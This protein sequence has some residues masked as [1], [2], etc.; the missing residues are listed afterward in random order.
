MFRKYLITGLLIWLPLGITLLILETI[1]GWMDQSLLLLPPP[2]RPEALL[3]FRIPGLG[4]LLAV[5]VLLLTGVLARNIVGRRLLLW[6]E[7]LLGRIPIVRSIYSSVKQVS[8]TMLSPK[9]NAFRKV[10][11]VEFPQPEQWTLAFV[12]GEPAGAVAE[13]L[14][15]GWVTVYVPTAPNPTSGYVL[16]LPPSRVRDVEV[17]IDDALKYHV[18]LGVVE[19]GAR[20]TRPAVLTSAPPSSTEHP[21]RAPS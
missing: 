18:S 7:R 17:S 5:A 13:Q 15:E 12:V 6:W 19:P 4:A 11:L 16:M 3:G 14:G 2:W 10:V 1:I 20:S 21:L 8:D 9:G